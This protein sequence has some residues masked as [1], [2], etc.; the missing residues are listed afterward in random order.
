MNRD[1]FLKYIHRPE[2]LS[3]ESLNDIQELLSEF[4]YFQTGHLLF[5]KNLHNVKSIRFENQLKVSSVFAHDRSVLYT[6]LHAPA[7]KVIPVTPTGEEPLG[8]ET[9]GPLIQPAGREAGA[10]EKKDASRNGKPAGK[11]EEAADIPEKEMTG[12][13]DEKNQRGL[14]EEERREKAEIKAEE[15]S[16][17][18]VPA[19][20]EATEE[21]P[22]KDEKGEPGSVAERIMKQVEE[23]RKR[24]EEGTL[25]GTE[26]EPEER[27]GPLR[28]E[29][30]QGEGDLFVLTDEAA[31][32]PLP[33]KP[34]ETTGL[35]PATGE[36]LEIDEHEEEPQAGEP[37]IKEKEE[38]KEKRTGPSLQQEP[39]DSAS[40]E[41]KTQNENGQKT[42]IKSNSHS[43]SQWLEMLSGE[44]ADSSSGQEEKKDQ[45]DPPVRRQHDLIDRFLEKNPRIVPRDEKADEAEDISR[46]SVEES[47]GLFTDTLAQIYVRQGYYSKAIFAYEKLSLKYP[48]KSSYFASQIQKIQ[49][50]IKQKTK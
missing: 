20:A 33:E 46:D 5:L 21:E 36:I 13:K 28:E 30:R 22:V 19:G 3:Q 17:P 23:A 11:E 47:E 6:L 49:E 4:P 43:F 50:L 14:Q 37:E 18:P 42:G 27:S 15:D 44:P 38:K 1:Q 26:G 10:S 2:D 24:R 48:E 41:K 9:P 25:Y 7:G 29:E 34:E 32:A 35:S 39:Q 8:E 40:A 16:G 31:E 45:S 12:E